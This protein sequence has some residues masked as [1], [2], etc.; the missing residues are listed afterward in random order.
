MLALYD[1]TRIAL[2][3]IHMELLLLDYE[4]MINTAGLALEVKE[5]NTLFIE[6]PHEMDTLIVSPQ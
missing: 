1:Q 5:G 2:K 6:T 3:E 4:Q